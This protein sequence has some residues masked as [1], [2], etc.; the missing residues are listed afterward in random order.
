MSTQ[1]TP[2]LTDTQRREILNSEYR[3]VLANIKPNMAGRYSRS[4]LN[5]AKGIAKRRALAI[6]DA[7]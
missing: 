2:S 7:A 1:Q 3:A 6:I 4:Q 5:A